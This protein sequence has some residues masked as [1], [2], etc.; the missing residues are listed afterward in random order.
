[1]KATLEHLQSFHGLLNNLHYKYPMFKSFI[2]NLVEILSIW[3][4]KWDSMHCVSFVRSAKFVC[5]C[6][7]EF[8]YFPH[9]AWCID[10]IYKETQK[11]K[12]RIWRSLS[13]RTWAHDIIIKITR[14]K[15]EPL[16]SLG[17]ISY[18]QWDI[19]KT[20]YCWR[21]KRTIIMVLND[22]NFLS[23]P[24]EMK[25]QIYYFHTSC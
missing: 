14:K 5:V 21:G 11:C 18:P 9:V 4:V 17:L 24:L 15:A 1:M 3:H 12:I 22:E 20:F 2:F 6:V 16:L 13:P 7:C 23:C 19:I 25:D 10:S 8:F